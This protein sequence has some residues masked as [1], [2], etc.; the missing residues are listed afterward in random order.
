MM[1]VMNHLEMASS[2]EASR[3]NGGGDW[4]R[5]QI[6]ATWIL[7]RILD[8]DIKPNRY[9]QFRLVYVEESIR[10]S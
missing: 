4:R 3:E 7:V 2:K 8:S 5:F 1:I 9:V 10:K 6:S